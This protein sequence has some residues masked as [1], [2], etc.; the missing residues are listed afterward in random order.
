MTAVDVCFTV[1]VDSG[2]AAIVPETLSVGSI[3]GT[4]YDFTVVDETVVGSDV[5]DSSA[6]GDSVLCSDTEV[7]V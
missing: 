5:F 3:T 7:V 2:S 4:V 6:G 1:V